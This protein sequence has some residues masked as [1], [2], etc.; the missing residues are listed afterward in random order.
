MR[1]KQGSKFATTPR[2]KD[3][4]SMKK[5][6]KESESKIH[7]KE[8]KSRKR[9]NLAFIHLDRAEKLALDLLKICGDTTE[10]FAEL[11][12]IDEGVR[13]S[14]GLLVVEKQE[15][16]QQNGKEF[17]EKI[18]EIHN[19]IV[20]HVKFVKNYVKDVENLGTRHDAAS[21]KSL[22]AEG[23][24]TATTSILSPQRSMYGSRLELRLAS[25]RHAL[26]QKMLA[27]EKTKIM[28]MVSETETALEGDEEEEGSDPHPPN[29]GGSKKRKR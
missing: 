10:K 21:T 27:I 14:T 16:I 3:I 11:T 25:E 26:L 6:E 1:G 5:P 15:Q 20:P 19:L 28:E 18:E 22:D 13:T 4:S 23:G 9:T 24:A 8:L 7:L 29:G 12:Q 17:R 2:G